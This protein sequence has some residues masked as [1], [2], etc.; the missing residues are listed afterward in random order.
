[1]N[2]SYIIAPLVL[3][4]GF[5]FIYKNFT[6]DYAVQIA[7]EEAEKAEIAAQEAA[8]KAEAER[9]AKE[10]ADRRTA[11][12]EAEEARKIAERQAKWEAEGATIAADTARY[13]EGAAK[14]AKEAA[15]LEMKLLE[16]RNAREKLAGEA[17]ALMKD[18]ELGRI[19]KR[20]AEMKE[21]RMVEMVARR[22]Q[23]S[24]LTKL[25]TLVAAPAKK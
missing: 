1:M 11:E 14:A 12:R 13:K 20:N 5:G 10:D 19:A 25:P 15:E 8:T 16:L 23:E 18:V 3:L 24:A 9:K 22:A 7:A 6:A 4:A 2:K 21:Q 17:F